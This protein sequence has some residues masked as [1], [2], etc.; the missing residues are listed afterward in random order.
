[1]S[2]LEEMRRIAARR[3]LSHNNN[4]GTEVLVIKE[5]TFACARGPYRKLD[6]PIRAED[7]AKF[8]E[9]CAANIDALLAVAD[10][11]RRF[12]EVGAENYREIELLQEKMKEA[13]AALETARSA[14]CG[15]IKA[16]QSETR[17]DFDEIPNIQAYCNHEY[18]SFG[19]WGQRCRTCGKMK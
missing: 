6:G 15:E 14:E 10:I 8:I 18:H 5:G 17:R 12:I 11:A 3:T 2:K 4:L 7:D 1:M 19:I 16:D 9:M 13:L